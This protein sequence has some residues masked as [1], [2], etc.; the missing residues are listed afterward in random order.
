MQQSLG[1][2]AL[3][4]AYVKACQQ[5]ESVQD[6]ERTRLL[7]MRNMLLEDE[8]DDL[9]TQLALD[10]DCIEGL[11]CYIEGLREDLEVAAGNLEN[12]GGDLRIKSRESETLKVICEDGFCTGS[13][14]LTS[15]S[16]GT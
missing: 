12:V 6:A 11:E 15:T 5:V 1:T 14:K 7:R 10:D 16:G 9:H 13:S 8:N 4:M 2:R 3:E